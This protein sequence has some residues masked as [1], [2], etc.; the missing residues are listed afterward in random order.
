MVDFFGPTKGSHDGIEP[1]F[2]GDEGFP[3]FS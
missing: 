2:L 3:L 1:Y